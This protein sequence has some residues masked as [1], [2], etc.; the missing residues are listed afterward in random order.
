[1]NET[2]WKHSE[3]KWKP[4]NKQAAMIVRK[5]TGYSVPPREPPKLAPTLAQRLAAESK[6]RVERIARLEQ[7]LK[8]RKER[9]AA[10]KLKIMPKTKVWRNM[11][12]AKHLRRMAK[13]RGLPTPSKEVIRAARM[14]DPNYGK[15]LWK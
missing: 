15:P 14:A 12:L 9:R 4:R 5:A 8:E 1:M 7:E 11:W 13:S 3:K 6:I 2:L 10:S